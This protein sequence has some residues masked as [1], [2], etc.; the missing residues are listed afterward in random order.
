MLKKLFIILILFI[1]I[2]GLGY[3]F[4]YLPSQEPDEPVEEQVNLTKLSDPTVISPVNSYDN[5]SLWYG[6]ST[7]RLMQYDL[8]ANNATEYPLPQIV[9]N[10]FKKV[11][12]PKQG[13]DFIAISDFNDVAQYSYFSFKEKQYKLLPRNIVNLDWMG[14]SSKIVIIWEGT[15][16]KTSLVVSNPD[17]SGY[18]V[19]REL[20]WPDMVVKA[21]PTNDTALVYRANSADPVS[22]IYLFDLATGTYV[23]S[24]AEG[25]STGAVWSPKGDSFIFTRLVDGKNKV[26]LH[27]LSTG[28]NTE[29]G[30][31]TSI[32]KI[33]YNDDGTKVYIAVLSEELN[34]E[35]IWEYDVS[36]KEMI[37]VFNSATHR[38]K[39][40]IAIGSELF[41]LNHENALYSFK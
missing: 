10:S 20:P 16:K 38:V 9:G 27:N 8:S 13:N 25:R 15:D 1:F 41:F 3:Y 19:L 18:K 31:S 30:L 39:N 14:N 22:K 34:R 36:N 28:V 29:T 40:I 6:L 21:S 2:S 7:G 32:D 24:V 26:L 35:D 17:A 23:E 11:Y 33:A 5:N 4:W 12:W 37:S